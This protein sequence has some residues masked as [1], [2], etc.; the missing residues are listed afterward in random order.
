MISVLVFFNG[1]YDFSIFH[2]LIKYTKQIILKIKI[3]TQ[4][5]INYQFILEKLLPIYLL[6][7]KIN[8][9]NNTLCI[10][11]AFNT[12]FTINPLYDTQS[13]T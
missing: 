12:L 11:T 2:D 6:N 13:P 8:Q 3:K 7:Q 1:F 9:L 5:N 4:N 10:L